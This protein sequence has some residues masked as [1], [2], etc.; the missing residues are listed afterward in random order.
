[1]F[2]VLNRKGMWSSSNPLEKTETIKQT[3][4]FNKAPA[5][6]E[7]EFADEGRIKFHSLITSRSL[8]S[9]QELHSSCATNTV[10]PQRSLQGNKGF[11]SQHLTRWDV[12][13]QKQ[14]RALGPALSPPP[15]C[16]WPGMYP[17]VT[18]P[19]PTATSETL[20]ELEFL[21]LIA[22]ILQCQRI[23]TR[24]S[25]ILPFSSRHVTFDT[26]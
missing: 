18:L 8:L 17:Q 14:S 7:M 24:L 19:C 13:P 11:F 5:Q 22:L 23:Q 25:L 16:E 20:Y 3:K 6:G 9:A 10:P 2:C 4:S 15:C 1:M 21:Q 12:W 26:E